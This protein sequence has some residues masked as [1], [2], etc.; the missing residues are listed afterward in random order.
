MPAPAVGIALWT[1]IIGVLPGLLKSL[2]SLLGISAVT[3]IGITAASDA[4]LNFAQA[5]LN[6][7]PSQ[8]LQIFGILRL[9]VAMAMILSAQV[10]RI[11]LQG[12]TTWRK[13]KAG[14]F[15]A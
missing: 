9:D 15:T 12:L 6:G 3:Y 13:N 4:L 5:Q 11:T 7:L 14:I 8:A 10:A 1:F 2:F